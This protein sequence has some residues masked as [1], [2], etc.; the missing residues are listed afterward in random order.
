MLFQIY[1][2]Y[3]FLKI[4][5][6]YFFENVEKAVCGGFASINWDIDWY[7]TWVLLGIP[8]FLTLDTLVMKINKSGSEDWWEI[9]LLF[10]YALRSPLLLPGERRLLQH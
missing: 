5:C 4:P 1:L 6:S 3:S 8:E 7:A 2:E 10:P 9:V